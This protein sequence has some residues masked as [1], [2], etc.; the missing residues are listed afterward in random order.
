MR[1]EKLFSLFLGSP[2]RVLVFFFGACCY[3]ETIV[4]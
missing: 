2:F 1:G 4:T 3:V